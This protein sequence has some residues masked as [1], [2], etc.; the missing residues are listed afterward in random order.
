MDAE[1][2][3]AFGN[4]SVLHVENAGR[5]CRVPHHFNRLLADGAACAKDLDFSRCS[6]RTLP[7]WMPLDHIPKGTCPAVTTPRDDIC[8]NGAA[9]NREVLRSAWCSY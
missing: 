7:H 1:S 6:H 8:G 9:W 2:F 3:G 4:S 5:T